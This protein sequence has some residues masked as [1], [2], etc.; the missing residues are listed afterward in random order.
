[1]HKKNRKPKRTFI[2]QAIGDTLKKINRNFSSKHDK[3]EFI[4]QSKWQEIVGSYFCDFSEPINIIKLQD[5]ENEIGEKVYKKLL[6]VSVAPAA[7]VE[8]Q[9]FKDK[10]LEKINSYFGYKAIVDLRIQQNYIIKENVKIANKNV[11][12]FNLTDTEKKTISK[13]VKLI[14]DQNLKKSLINL[15]RNIAKENK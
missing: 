3:I 10:I 7:A 5:F 4:I 9:H 1:M 8:F 13:E 6:N 15:G 2:P 11:N 12:K 14:N